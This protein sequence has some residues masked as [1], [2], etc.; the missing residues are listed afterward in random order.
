M[1][2]KHRDVFVSLHDSSLFPFFSLNEFSEYFGFTES[3]VDEIL[4]ESNLS[5]KSKE[6]KAWYNGYKIG[7]TV[8]HNPWSIVNCIKQQ[9]ELKPHWVNTSDN[10]LIKD[11]LK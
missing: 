6:I 2:D 10:Q 4:R 11:L 5:F 3:E 7:E 1:I 9:R 8:I